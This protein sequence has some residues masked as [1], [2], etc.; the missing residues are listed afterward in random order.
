MTRHVWIVDNDASKYNTPEA[1]CSAARRLREEGIEWKI[2][3]TSQHMAPRQIQDPDAII[4]DNDTG[5]GLVTLPMLLD[6]F[7]VPT[8]YV[9]V[10]DRTQLKNQFDAIMDGRYPSS[11]TGHADPRIIE[12]KGVVLIRK[13]GRN[14]NKDYGAEKLQND[15]YQF[16]T[17]ASR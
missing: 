17:T 5:D 11:L 6:M 9:T 7:S 12:E 16:L 1:L 8:A 15:L 2:H 3:P 4:V 13:A 10:Y 14:V